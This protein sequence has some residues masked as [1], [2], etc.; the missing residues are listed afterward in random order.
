MRRCDVIGCD[1][2]AE[3]Q[4]KIGEILFSVCAERHMDKIFDL[5]VQYEN[6][7]TTLNKNFYNMVR[8]MDVPTDEAP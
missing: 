1:K 2:I 5:K 4:F 6:A 7:L 8:N 3:S